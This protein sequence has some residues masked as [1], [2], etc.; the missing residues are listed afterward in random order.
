MSEFWDSR[1]STNEYIYSKNPNQYFKE[2]IDSLSVGNILLIAEGEGRNAVYAAKKGWHATA[3]DNSKVAREK[4]LKL[5]KENM[6]EIEYISKSYKHFE[7]IENSYDAIAI[8][9]FHIPSNERKR[10][11]EKMCNALRFGG[12]LIIHSCNKR[13]INYG[14]GGPKDVDILYDVKDIL[15]DFSEL[16]TIEAYEKIIELDEGNLHKGKAEII[17]YFGVK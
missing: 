14:S 11:H 6:V 7:F 3:L 10:M 13:Q 9:N 8:I 2:K 12:H 5:A 16:K 15:E 1:Y 17:R 4:A